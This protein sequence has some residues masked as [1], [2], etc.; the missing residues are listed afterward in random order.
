MTT[1]TIK[2]FRERIGDRLRLNFHPGQLR[3]WDSKARFPVMCAG[4]QGGKTCF[5]PEWLRREIAEKGPGDYI[6]ITSTFPLLDLKLLPECLEVFQHIHQ[7][8][9][10]KESKKCFYF[11]DGQTKIFFGSAENPESIESATA[12][13]AICDEIGQK[14]FKRESWDA[15]ERRLGIYQARALML[16]TL[17]N[18]GWFVTEIYNKAKAG[19]DGFELIQFDSITNPAFPKAEFERQKAMK[20]AWKFDMFYRG[21]FSRPAGIVYDAFNEATCKI[22]RFELPKTWARFVG[23]DFGSANPAAMFYAQDPAT[24]YFFAYQEYLPGRGRSPYQHVQVWKEMVAGLNVLKRAG[25]SHQEEEVRQA[26]TQQ[27]WP[28]QEPKIRDVKVQIERVYALHKLNKL[29]VFNDLLAYLDQKM[30]FS[31]KLN[32][33]YEPTDEFEDE[34]SMHLLAAE[35]Y[36]LSD[37]T[38]DKVSEQVLAGKGQGESW[39]Y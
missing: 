20:P 37:F 6:A 27:G 35:R 15:V 30:S 4:T 24:G 32:D 22:S 21:R 16:T 10:Y 17:Y 25:G 12:K 39:Y 2:P 14:Q 1:L 5:A 28:I 33:R 18:T 34:K 19:V 9:E 3:A 31:Y 11:K 8:G 26:Y 36:I 7:L 38:P 23:H 13:G 29:F